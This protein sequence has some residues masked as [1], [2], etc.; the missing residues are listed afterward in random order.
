MMLSSAVS[1]NC[2][3]QIGAEINVKKFS[4]EGWNSDDPFV[5]TVRSRPIIPLFGD[6]GDNDA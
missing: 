5:K 1:T 4:R 3:S 2:A 6:L